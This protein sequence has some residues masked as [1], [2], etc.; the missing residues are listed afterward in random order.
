MNNKLIKA[1]DILKKYNQDHLLYFYDDLSVHEK[2]LLLDDIIN[3]NFEKIL[4]LYQNSMKPNS[5]N[6][7]IS[8]LKHYVK[9]H[10][11]DKLARKYSKIGE[12]EIQKGSFAVVTMA[13]GQG[14]RLGY[15]GPKGT[16]EIKFIFGRKSLFEIL[17]DELKKANKLYNVIIPWYIMVSEENKKQT[18]EFFEEKNYFS[19]PKENVKFFVQDTIPLVDENGK[20]ILQEYYKIKKVSNG[21][22]NVF[23]S[24]CKANII[25]EMKSKKI[26]WIHFAGIDNILIKNVD[27]LFLGMMIDQKMQIASKSIFKEN[28]LDNIAVYCKKDLKPAILDYDEIDLELSESKDKNGEFLYREANMLS[29]LMT[30]KAVE[31]VSTKSLPYHRAHKKNP[32]INEEGTKIVPTKPNSFKFEN[33]IFDSF[34]YFDDMLLLRV[35]SEDEFA[36]IKAFTGE[37][38][39]ESAKE[40]YEKY[41]NLH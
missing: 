39:P 26:K 18:I 23:K 21:N 38:T 16:Y 14:T 9:E 24:M 34:S 2:E 3:L 41:W 35:K 13:G 32:I 15:K 20:I 30:L 10:L 36:P 12:K 7:T 29:H 4:T 11:S 17:C 19:Y 40:K 28:P 1:K 6:Y 33:F 5:T 27:P 25:D 31:L 37:Y 22:G 8:P